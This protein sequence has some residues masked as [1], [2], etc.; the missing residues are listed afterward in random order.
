M[1]VVVGVEGDEP[2]SPMRL[3]PVCRAGTAFE[4]DLEVSAA[5]MISRRGLPIDGLQCAVWCAVTPSL[6]EGDA[7]SVGV[8]EARFLRMSK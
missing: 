7:E 1:L 2:G 8:R 6:P 3:V 4:V 5:V